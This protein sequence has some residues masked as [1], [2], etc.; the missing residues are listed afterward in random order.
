MRSYRDNW[1]KKTERGVL[2]KIMVGLVLVVVIGVLR[3]LM[4]K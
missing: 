1:Q 3:W 2:T 4:G